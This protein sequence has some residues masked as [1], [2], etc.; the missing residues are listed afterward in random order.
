MYLLSTYKHKHTTWFQV[1]IISFN[2]CNQQLG[3]SGTN[4][5]GGAECLSQGQE[6]AL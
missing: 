5:R 3:Q 2:S 6:A 4:S 1:N